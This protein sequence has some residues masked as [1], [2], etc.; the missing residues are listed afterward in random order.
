MLRIHFYV[1]RLSNGI[2]EGSAHGV[3]DHREGTCMS[4]V[5]MVAH[6][7]ADIDFQ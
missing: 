2:E 1:Q 6:N 7:F 3:I 5:Y 4:Y